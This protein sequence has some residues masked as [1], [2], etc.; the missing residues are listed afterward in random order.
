MEMYDGVFGH[1]DAKNKVLYTR[2]GNDIYLP[3][4]IQQQMPLFDVT[5]EL[6]GGAGRF[7]EFAGLFNS[8]DIADSR[9]GHR[10]NA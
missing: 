8:G 9:D 1:Y 4:F 7:S 6:Y 5:A 2:Q 3:Q 10:C